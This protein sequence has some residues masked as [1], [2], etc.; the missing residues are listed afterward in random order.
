M[1][2]LGCIILGSTISQSEAFLVAFDLVR[3]T[4]IWLRHMTKPNLTH[5]ARHLSAHIL[6][7]CIGSLE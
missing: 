5:T 3:S 1:A 6:M 7:K 4:E 2:I